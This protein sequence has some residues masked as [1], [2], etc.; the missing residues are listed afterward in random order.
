LKF[1]GW[2]SESRV[3]HWRKKQPP[4]L[5]L[6]VGRKGGFLSLEIGWFRKGEKSRPPNHVSET[7]YHKSRLEGIGQTR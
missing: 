4:D 7:E 3:E 6:R 2:D 1:Q 5:N